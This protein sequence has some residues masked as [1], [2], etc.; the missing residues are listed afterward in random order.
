M[1]SSPASIP[2]F[3][4]ASTTGLFSEVDSKSMVQTTTPKPSKDSKTS[5]VPRYEVTA[6]R[7]L[8]S[9][10]YQPHLFRLYVNDVI[11]N[12][13][14]TR[15]AHTSDCADTATFNHTGLRWSETKRPTGQTLLSRP[16]PSLPERSSC[17]RPSFSS[18]SCSRWFGR[19]RHYY[20]NS[21]CAVCMSALDQD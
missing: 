4:C 3:S 18:S 17:V 21:T 15:R 1:P 13:S 5:T 11:N 10:I 16:K 6:K 2:A 12:L 7:R 8:D 14:A 9:L 20:M 19:E